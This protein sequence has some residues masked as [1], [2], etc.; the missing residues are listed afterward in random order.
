MVLSPFAPPP[1]ILQDGQL[2]RSD[3]GEEDSDCWNLSPDYALKISAETGEKTAM[4]IS[5][6]GNLT[7]MVVSE[8]LL[9]ER[10]ISCTTVFGNDKVVGVLSPQKP[11]EVV[12]V[13][14]HEGK[15]QRWVQLCT[16]T[17]LKGTALG[18]SHV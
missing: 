6:N 11:K 3:E 12:M 13:D 2:G 18:G 15:L 14:T 16:P 9:T 8:S 7:V 1:P 4:Y 10:S 17:T 5:A